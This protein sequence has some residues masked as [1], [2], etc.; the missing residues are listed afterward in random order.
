MI[1]ESQHIRALGADPDWTV[2]Q[3]R[4]FLKCGNVRAQAVV[5]KAICYRILSKEQDQWGRHLVNWDVYH[6]Y[7]PNNLLKE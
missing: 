3:I 2:I 1:V 7:F 6:T 4:K 5:D